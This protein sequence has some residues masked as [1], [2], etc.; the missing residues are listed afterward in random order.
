MEIAALKIF[1]DVA[2]C[3]SFA[4]VARDR[5]ADPSTVSR[6]IAHLEHELGLRLFQRTTR[7]VTLTEGGQIYLSHIERLLEDMD[8]AQDEA[9]AVST[10]PTG[11][12]R[13]TASIAFGQFCLTPL[14]PR[15][16]EQFPGL[17]Y[18]LVLADA[19][20]DLVSERIDLAVRLG[21]RVTGN[22]VST[23]LFDNHYRVC[24][25]PDYLKRHG[26]IRQPLDL[27]SHKCL[28]M[29]PAADDGH[30]VARDR[31]GISVEIPVTSDIVISSVMA[32]RQCALDGLGPVMLIAW[33][34]DE[35]IEAGR[36]VELL[37]GYEITGAHARTSAWL[38]YPSKHYLPLK[39]RVT[40]DFLKREL[41]RICEPASW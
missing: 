10:Q 16:R 18:E 22:V 39:A 14:L 26:M 1:V 4:A 24:A 21:D 30:W 19:P 3:G 25:S 2:R 8:I 29:R 5:D 31:S 12:I 38:V 20:I 27:I 23:K 13:I 34:V 15:M 32:L 6:T 7:S 9:L 17:R 33:M 35:D 37:P 40:I 41:A 36:L 28:L 11:T